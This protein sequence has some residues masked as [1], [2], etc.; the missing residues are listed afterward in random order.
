MSENC[1]CGSGGSCCGQHEGCCGDEQ[2][3]DILID[4]LY[5]DLE[6][7]DRCCG[8]DE[9]LSEAI[10]KVAELFSAAGLKPVLRKIKIESVQ[11]AEE[12]RFTSSPT[13]RINGRDIAASVQENSCTSC[14]EICGD[15]VN[16]R[17]WEYDGN[18]YEVPPVGFLV[19]ALLKGVYAPESLVK[20][21]K[22]Y[23]V[24]ENIRT[25]FAGTAD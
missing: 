17:V 6:T 13:I 2:K 22:E 23:T 25:F 10:R 14:G 19:D 11:M 24:P 21:V 3:K 1:G 7:C 16:C 15:D 4:F 8:T 20:P 5:L 18:R 9:V 12:Y